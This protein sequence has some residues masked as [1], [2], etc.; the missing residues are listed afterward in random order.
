MTVQ[1]NY[2]I[3]HL[4][5]NCLLYSCVLRIPQTTCFI[6]VTTETVYIYFSGK[7]KGNSY[8]KT[9]EGCQ[10]ADSRQRTN[11]HANRTLLNPPRVWLY[12]IPPVDYLHGTRHGQHSTVIIHHPLTNIPVPLTS[13]EMKNVF[14]FLFNMSRER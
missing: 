4:Q 13:I 12:N 10:T 1:S 6:I 11:S 2:I 5:Y 3:Y 7:V 14:F 8:C 9:H